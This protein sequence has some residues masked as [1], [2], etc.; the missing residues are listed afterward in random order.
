MY[1]CIGIGECNHGLACQAVCKHTLT[2]RGQMWLHL[3]HICWGQICL[4]LYRSEGYFA[5]STHAI[6]GPLCH[7]ESTTVTHPHTHIMAHVQYAYRTWV[8]EL[9]RYNPCIH[10]R[11]SRC[12]AANTQLN[13]GQK[14]VELLLSLQACPLHALDVLKVKLSKLDPRFGN[15]C[16]LD[17]VRQKS[18]HLFACIAP[19]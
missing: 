18:K 8:Y 14:Q 5:I 6:N 15:I 11:S 9:L 13:R 19:T 1:T 7:I 16:R 3:L 17:D 4:R 10:T 2:G 12:L